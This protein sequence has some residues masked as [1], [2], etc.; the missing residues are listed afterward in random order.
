MSDAR[1]QVYYFVNG[2]VNREEKVIGGTDEDLFL[3]GLLNRVEDDRA[4]R[5]AE[6]IRKAVKEDPA[7]RPKGHAA[8]LEVAESIDPYEMR[9]GALYRKSDGSPVII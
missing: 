7:Y 4:H 5:E 2:Q 3:H 6:K 8:M 9:D 1:D